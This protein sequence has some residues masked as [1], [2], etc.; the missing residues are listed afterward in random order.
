MT[1]ATPGA[2]AEE[3]TTG[4]APRVC[5][6]C[7]SA[8]LATL[9]TIRTASIASLLSAAPTLDI[10]AEF[11]SIARL[12]YRQ[13]A[14]CDLRFFAPL[15]TGSERF[16][17]ELQKLDSYYLAEKP[18]FSF[19][20]GYL[21][22]EHNVLEVGCGAGAFGSSLRVAHYVGLE[23]SEQAAVAARSRGLNVL[24]ESI[25]DHA[26]THA[27]RYDVVCAFQVLE[28]VAQPGRFLQACVAAIKPGGL[29]VIS[30]PSADSFASGVPDFLLDLPPHHVTRWT[31][32]CL[33]SV[34]ERFSSEL[35]QLWHEPLQAVHRRMYMQSAMLRAIYGLSGRAVPVVSET[36]TTRAIAR[37]TWKL[38]AL[39][40]PI[41]NIRPRR[42]IS[43]T[44]VYRKTK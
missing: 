3:P 33:N 43:V 24:R 22:P 8:Q 10:T 2:H 37:M 21:R 35:L 9:Q 36:S 15:V 26:R 25:E 1:R 11:G 14:V 19:A 39:L 28:H 6:L 32:L 4:T 7:G 20:R 23:F 27:G 30:V 16:Y 12:E 5:P 17:Q 38:S 42:G 13:C 41:S 40:A 31:D 44:A 29:T 18:E 34:A